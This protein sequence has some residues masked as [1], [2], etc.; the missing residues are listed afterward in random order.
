MFNLSFHIPFHALR[1]K[2]CEDH[3]LDANG[4]R[5]RQFRDVSFL[6]LNSS[7]RLF[8]YEAKV[9]CLVAGTD[10]WHW[11][12][13]SE[14]KDLNFFSANSAI[15]QVAYAFVDTY[16]DNGGDAKETVENYHEDTIMKGGMLADPL[17]WGIADAGRTLTTP[18]EYFLLVFRTRSK[19]AKDEWEN[20]VEKIKSSVRE[21]E[22]VSF[23]SLV[24]TKQYAIRQ[25]E[26]CIVFIR[27]PPSHFKFL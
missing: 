17:A 5:L 7:E 25:W 6:N 19:Q 1:S 10:E 12:G 23:L 15:K 16:F 18:R 4:A 24:F 26:E 14:S 21:Y 9:S 2:V 27:K 8:L 13:T 11:V 3:R 22:Q 20:Q